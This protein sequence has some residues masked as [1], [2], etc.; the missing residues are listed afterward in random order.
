MRRLASCGPTAAITSMS[1]RSWLPPSSA[2]AL[3]ATSD[4]SP[5]ERSSI[6]SNR[7][8]FRGSWPPAPVRRLSGDRSAST[9]VVAEAASGE[10][11][12]CSWKSARAT[13]RY[14]VNVLP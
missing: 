13:G 12:V 9:A 14:K 10:A 7:R 4:N 3:S 5:W 6:T 1:V 8:G 2:T 11:S